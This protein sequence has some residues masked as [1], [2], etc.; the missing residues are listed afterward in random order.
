MSR[1]VAP[2]YVPTETD[3]LRVRVRTCGVIETQF[4]VG[5]TIFRYDLMI[6]LFGC[7]VTLFTGFTNLS[8][9]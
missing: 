5:E 9:L 7:G 2:N 4:Q 8:S 3:I 6:I 1:I